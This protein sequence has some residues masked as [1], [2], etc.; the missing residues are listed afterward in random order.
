MC[1]CF[2]FLVAVLFLL[3]NQW[4]WT[5]QC[6]LWAARILKQTEKRPLEKQFDLE[7]FQFRVVWNNYHEFKKSNTTKVKLGKKS[8]V[9]ESDRWRSLQPKSKNIDCIS[10]ILG[11]GLITL[12]LFL[13]YHF[14]VQMHYK[15]VTI[16]SK[17]WN[18]I[19]LDKMILWAFKV[20]VNNVKLCH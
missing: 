17:E 8:D 18:C 20:T 2:L 16:T 14:L 1:P 6:L 15:A 5:A 9:D 11:F 12:L 4:R 7:I 19:S 3:C 10:Y 13:Y